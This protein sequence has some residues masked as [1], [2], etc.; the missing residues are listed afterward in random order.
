M[1]RVGGIRVG[2][3]IVAING[4]DVSAWGR[5]AVTARLGALAQLE[6][7]ITFRFPPVTTSTSTSTGLPNAAE[8]LAKR[9]KAELRLVLKHDTA[10][11]ARRE[12]W[13]LI[14]AAWMEKWI[15]FVAQDGPLPGPITNGNLLEPLWQERLTGG[16]LSTTLVRLV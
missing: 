12:C 15:Q 11:L 4:D 6:R 16:M 8:D 10:T 5:E 9:R 1:E 14:D 13:F 7:T 3:T 2:S